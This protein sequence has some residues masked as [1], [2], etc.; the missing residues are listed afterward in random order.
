M[1]DGEA[2]LVE[3][4]LPVGVDAAREGR[5]GLEPVPHDVR[6]RVVG[7]PPRDDGREPDRQVRQP[8]LRVHRSHD[9]ADARSCSACAARPATRSTT[10]RRTGSRATR[11]AC[12]CP[13]STSS[14]ASATTAPPSSATAGPLPR[15]R[16]ASSRTS[17]CSTS[18]RPTTG[19]AA[20]GASGR[21]RRRR[22]RG[23]RLRAR[24]RRATCPRSR[25]PTDD[26][27][28]LDPRGHR[29]ER[30]GRA[31][32]PEPVTH[33]RTPI[34]DA[35]G[36]D[37]PIVQT[38]MGWVAGPRLVTRDRERGRARHPRVGD[39]DL[40]PARRPRSARCKARTDRPFGVNLRADAEDADAAR[41]AAHRARACR[42][43]RSRSR[44]ASSRSRAEGRGHRGGAVDRRAPPRGEGRG[45]GRRR[46]DRAGRR[47]RRPHRLGRRP[48][49]S[50][51][52]S[53]TRSTSR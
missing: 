2:L 36:I 37:V 26:E 53:S 35:F 29:P 46:G 5:G 40:R 17:A 11:R 31:G 48:R 1:T 50:S 52:R 45:V 19:C 30:P 47:G 18:R 23:D 27:L 16:A 21:D 20:L 33:L 41:R 43:R 4:I 51:P 42:S 7:P 9:A 25:L 22:R 3:N 28:Q 14:A 39:D 32:S 10:R 38:G 8:E 44:R 13:R 34:C 15:D 6:R 24:D 12:S 49:C